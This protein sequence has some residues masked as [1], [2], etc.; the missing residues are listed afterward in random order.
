MGVGVLHDITERKR[1]GQEIK[2]LNDSL[3]KRNRELEFANKEMESFIYS[4][5]HDLRGPLRH[6][7]GFSEILMK[8]IADKIDEKEKRHFSR[9]Q[10]GT[11]KMSRLIDDLLKLS[12]IARQEMQ[13]KSFDLSEMASSIIADLREAD[14]DRSVKV[15][16]KSRLE[17][18]ADPGLIEIALSNLLPNA[19]KFTKK[20]EHARIELGTMDQDGMIIYYVRDNGAGFDQQFAEKM[21][22]PFHR[23][24]LEEDFEGTGIG[25]AIVERII[26]RHGGKVW[27][28]GE[29]GKGATIY[30]SIK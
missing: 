21:F 18:F 23:L 17:V 12:R 11:E 13:R 19:W 14:P 16:I 2:R 26:I 28:E 4:V 24:H 30:F 5:S 9:I 20:T 29:V 22:R 8:H 10:D 15:D 3:L 25:L 7:Y 1:A 27:A 6:I